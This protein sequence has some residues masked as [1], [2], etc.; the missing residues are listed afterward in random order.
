MKVDAYNHQALIVLCLEIVSKLLQ[1]S[2]WDRA[3]VQR[4]E[5]CCLGRVLKAGLWNTR[6]ATLAI[7]PDNFLFGFDLPV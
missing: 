7:I 6:A 5:R 4:L 2:K 3:K 1:T